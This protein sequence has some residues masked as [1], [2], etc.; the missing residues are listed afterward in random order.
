LWIPPY[1][2]SFAKGIVLIGTVAVYT[3]IKTKVEDKLAPC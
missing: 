2:Q 1:W 3:L